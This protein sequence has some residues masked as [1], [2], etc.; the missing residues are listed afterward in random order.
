MARTAVTSD[1]YAILGVTPAAE[2]VVIRAAYRALIRHYHPDTNPDPEAQERVREINAA[3]AVLR[4]PAKR[5]DYDAQRGSPK[6]WAEEEIRLPPE[7]ALRPPAAMRNIGLASAAIALGLVVAVWALPKPLAPAGH[8]ASIPT[9]GQ[10]QRKKIEPIVELEP[11]SERLARLREQSGLVPRTVDIGPPVPDAD[12]V[13][14]VAEA[15]E[16]PAVALPRVEV[17]VR[18]MPGSRH[19]VPK[20]VHAPSTSPVR[21]ATLPEAPKPAED[22]AGCRPGGSVGVSVGCKNQRL[23]ALDRMA[24]G[25]FSQSMA[26][27]DPAKKALLLS[28]HTRSTATRS[29]CRSDSCVGDAYLRQMREISAIME[30]REL[31][32][33]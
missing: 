13:P 23:V 4:D 15:A 29:A 20:I 19:V 33:Q 14:A 10:P 32:P 5:A 1:Y 2:G 27:A 24:A 3:F 16:T 21:T 25:F 28:S 31:P 18:A 9:S 11:E 26:H 17:P 12:E 30:G 6:L 7:P 8:V 22:V